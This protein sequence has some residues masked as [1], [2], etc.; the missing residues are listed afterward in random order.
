MRILVEPNAHHLQNFGDVA[1]LQIAVERLAELWPDATIEVI[2]DNAG[3][4]QAYCPQAVA[5]PAAGRRAWFAES[6]IGS[7]VRDSL[8]SRLSAIVS[9]AEANVRRRWPRAAQRALAAKHKAKGDESD[10]VDCFVSAVRSADLLVVSGAGAITDEFAPL[11]LTILD[12]VELA[13]RRGIPTA[14]MGQGIGPISRRSLNRRAAAVLP[15]VDLI[16][17]RE[18]VCGLPLLRS[19]GVPEERIRVTGDDAMELA[20]RAG[21]STDGAHALG[22]SIRRSRYSGVTDPAQASVATALRRAA[23]ELEADLTSLP[24]SSYEKEDDASAIGEMLQTA[25]E[26]EIPATPLELIDRTR[27]CRVVVT[28]SYHAAVFA[29]A[30]GTPAIGLAASEY[31]R[32][33]FAGL[34]DLFGPECRVV[35]LD[36]PDLSAALSHEIRE[37]W[38][39]TPEARSQLRRAAQGQ[40]DASNAAYRELTMLQR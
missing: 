8:P 22:V 10:E 28:G 11:A 25:V 2:V 29:L 36:L 1:M 5:V 26:A 20:F 37:A 3:L 13:S 17:L 6:L 32:A 35:R 27:S 30:Q 14:M 33:K 40:V 24:I 31:Y 21:S 23:E 9:S 12:L 16:G 39:A 7:R 38:V 34:I 15:R 18:R 19:F 4:L